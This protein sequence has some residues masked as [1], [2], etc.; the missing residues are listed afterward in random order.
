MKTVLNTKNYNLLD[1][2]MFLGESLGLQRFDVIK[3]PKFKDLYEKQQEFM[4]RPNEISLVNDRMQY[5]QLS[6][7]ERFVFDTNLRFQTMGDSMLS[8]SIETLKKHVSNTEL[9][10]AMSVWAMMECVHSE[11]Y[12]WI[13]NNVAKDPTFFF[14]S[15][16]DDENI[17]TRAF[18]IKNN[19]DSLLGNEE[20]D[21]DIRESI[22]KC[23]LSLQVAEGIF[24]YNS[25]A[26]SFWFGSRGI[27]RGNADIIKLI[28]RDENL[29]VAITQNIFKNW[30]KD[31]KEG[32]QDILK[33]NE[34]LVYSVYDEAVKSE[35]KWAEY[36][37]SQ[38][39]LIGLN[40]NILSQYVEWLANNRLTNLGYKKLYKTSSNPLGGWMEEYVDSSKTA[41]MP[42]EHE[43]TSYKKGA[44]NNTIDYSLFKEMEL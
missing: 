39:D 8:R 20:T 28:A 17:K 34:D 14:D 26:C 24:F 10:Y 42:Q 30:K 41:S 44:I 18:E 4:W 12:T 3:Y 2:P 32:F 37:F 6:D 22:F 9:E 23:V 29:H 5:E 13:L 15:I 33:K 38:G 11:S 27:M 1:Q 25:F 43:I 7:V 21:N 35:K 36:L 19:F 31:S 40:E 16:L